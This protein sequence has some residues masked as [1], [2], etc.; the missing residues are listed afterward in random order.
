MQYPVIVEHDNGIY[1]AL[2]PA[3]S[4]LS[5]EGS[6]RDEAVK[7]A[8][9]AAEAYLANVEVTAIEVGLPQEQSPQPGTPQ[10]WMQ[11]LEPFA[12]D[13]EAI[14]EHFAEIAAERARQGEEE[15]GLEAA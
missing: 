10:A 15:E 13:A 12:G 8:Q 2:I 5:A 3:L 14:R 1:R 7:N 9:Q 11:A 6:S 4:G